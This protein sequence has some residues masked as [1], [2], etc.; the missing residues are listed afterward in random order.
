MT[1]FCPIFLPDFKDA[2]RS[3]TDFGSD[4]EK[5]KKKEGGREGRKNSIQVME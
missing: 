5:N 2:H 4:L 1:S 3:K